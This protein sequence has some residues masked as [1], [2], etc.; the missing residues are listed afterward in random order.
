MTLTPQHHGIWG[1]VKTSVAG[2]KKALIHRYKNTAARN[3]TTNNRSLNNSLCE[4]CLLT[5]SC[6]K[7]FAF[8]ELQL[9]ITFRTSSSSDS[10]GHLTAA[11][12]LFSFFK[13]LQLLHLCMT[14]GRQSHIST[15]CKAESVWQFLSTNCWARAI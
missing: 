1:L 2:H 15:T 3:I 5:C 6:F 7:G 12:S 14:R 10:T 9:Y 4:A 11:L 8:L 13:V